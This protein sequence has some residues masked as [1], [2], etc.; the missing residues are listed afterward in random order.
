MTE[1]WRGQRRNGKIIVP[2]TRN[3]KVHFLEWV[4]GLENNN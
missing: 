3:I 1:R 4:F 2:N